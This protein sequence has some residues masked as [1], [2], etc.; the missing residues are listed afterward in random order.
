MKLLIFFLQICAIYGAKCPKNNWNCH[1]S[2]QCILLDYVCDK[3]K[4]PDCKYGEDEDYKFCVKWK[5]KYNT[6]TTTT[7]TLTTTSN[8][9]T[10]TT[11]T[12]TTSNT[13]TTT[14]NTL[15]TTSNTLTTN[16]DTLTTTS[17]TLTT[18]TNTLTTTSNT[19]TT[20]TNT[21]TTKTSSK[22]KPSLTN[23]HR[24]LFIKRKTYIYIIVILIQLIIISILF[25]KLNKK[26]ETVF[27]KE[28]NDIYLEPVKVND[29][30]ETI[31]DYETVL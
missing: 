26:K 28:Y 1:K 20:T 16:T 30:Y 2:G 3:Q 6:L 18:T 31:H 15:T 5:H 27:D 9:L 23:N 7:D 24:S 22:F 12:L 29:M 21:F 10:T 14:S 25:I 19:L 11:D 13:L 4:P 8:T 17:N